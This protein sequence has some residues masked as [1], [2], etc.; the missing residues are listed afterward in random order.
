MSALTRQKLWEERSRTKCDLEVESCDGGFV[1]AHSEVLSSASPFFEMAIWAQKHIMKNVDSE[2]ITVKI[3]CCSASTIIELIKFIYTGNLNK[4]NPFTVTDIYRGADFLCLDNLAQI[5]CD[6]FKN[7]ITFNDCIQ[8]VQTENTPWP[9]KRLET[10]GWAHLHARISYERSAD[11]L[12]SVSAKT[13]A[14]LVSSD[15][16]NAP[17][18]ELVWE[19]IISWAGC[20]AA[21][22]AQDVPKLAMLLRIGFLPF[23]YVLKEIIENP[24]VG[25]ATDI[26]T[27][28]RRRNLEADA[29][30]SKSV[31]HSGAVPTFMKPRLPYS[32]ILILGG[33]VLQ[34]NASASTDTVQ[35]FDFHTQQWLKPKVELRVPQGDDSFRR[36]AFQ[37][38]VLQ[39]H[40]LYLLGGAEN[41]AP[42]T[43]CD[44]LDLT[45]LKWSRVKDISFAK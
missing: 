40:D 24:M 13:M 21:D 2:R 14:A 15:R 37:K 1:L 30:V 33:K 3:P 9:D 44:K 5:C 41:G 35:I 32:L 4:L 36:L 28:I 23:S 34:G 10:L 42:S 43:R 29:V 19:L 6:Y 31:N 25:H 38:V 8:L 27:I 17:R 22:R 39:G 12:K 18:E 45:S 16:L 26:C 7:I 11:V 20:D